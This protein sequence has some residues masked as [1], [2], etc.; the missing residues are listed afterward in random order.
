MTVNERRS[1]LQTHDN[2]NRVLDYLITLEALCP[3]ESR[4]LSLRYIPDRLIIDRGSFPGY[5]M[6][7]CAEERPIETLASDLLEDINNELVARWVQVIIFE[8]S[9][10]EN[11]HSVVMEDRQ[12]QWNN[13]QILSRITKI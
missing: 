9:E 5:V 13:S 10:E 7:L 4:R 12:P 1:L 8:E 6:A 3:G 2:P 11:L